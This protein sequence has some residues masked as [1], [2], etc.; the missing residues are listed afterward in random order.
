MPDIMGKMDI[1]FPHLGIYL[2]NVPKSFTIGNFSIAMYGVVI[3]IAMLCGILLAGRIARKTGQNPDLY[4]DVAIW[5]I[6]FSVIGARTFYVIFFWDQGGYGEHP[7]SIFNLRQGGLAIAGGII[8]GVVTLLIYTRIKKQNLLQMM[9]TAGFGLI[10]GQIIG[11]WANFFNREVFG[12]W[13]DSLFAMRLPVE[14]VR[15]RDIDA[16]IAAHMSSSTNYIQVHPTFLYESLW[17]IGVLLLML[18]LVKKKR[19]HGQIALVYFAGYGI[20]RTWIE[21][22]RTDQLYFTGTTIPVNCV[23]GIAVAA[24]S[25]GLQI[26]NARRV[27]RGEL[28]A[29][30]FSEVPEYVKK[31]VKERKEES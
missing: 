3:A 14:M 20:G 13:T 22:V 5:L 12:R 10:L 1:A 21:L 11:R 27:R 16:T 8:G 25:I 7:L 2:H 26:T 29:I 19:Y 15:E 9:D 28:A 31:T 17:N 4:W 30:D 18:S 6:V 23:F 24:V